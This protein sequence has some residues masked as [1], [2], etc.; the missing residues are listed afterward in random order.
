[1]A[2]WHVV[3]HSSMHAIG[4][5]YPGGA[6]LRRS[7]RSGGFG[8]QPVAAAIHLD[9][10]VHVD[11]WCHDLVRVQFAEFADVLHLGDGQLGRHRHDRVEVGAGAPVDQVAPAIRLPGFDQ[12]DIVSSTCCRAVA[13]SSAMSH[14]VFISPMRRYVRR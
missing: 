12:R 7:G 13:G 8:G 4:L 10:A 3:M 11:P 9:H 5:T 1:M 2:D 6:A 14:A